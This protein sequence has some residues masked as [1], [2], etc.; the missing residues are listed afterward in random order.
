[1]ANYNYD[2]N[3]NLVGGQ[4]V[5][6][7]SYQSFRPDCGQIGRPS[8][9]YATSSLLANP[10]YSTNFVQ[11]PLVAG[12]NVVDYNGVPY[13]QGLSIYRGPVMTPY[14]GYR[15]VEPFIHHRNPIVPGY[16]LTSPCHPCDPK[17]EIYPGPQCIREPFVG[18]IDRSFVGGI[19]R[20]FVGGIDRS[21][22]TPRRRLRN[23]SN[24]YPGY[25]NVIAYPTTHSIPGPYLQSYIN[26][27]NRTYPYYSIELINLVD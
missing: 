27:P 24:Y 2:Y 17:R 23:R 9:P 5:I 8:Y 20:S 1:M 22:V 14:S 10:G 6:L 12:P 16:G 15:P 25:D 3:Y 4:P 21:F 19:D 26:I 11:P 7:D 18:G 13:T